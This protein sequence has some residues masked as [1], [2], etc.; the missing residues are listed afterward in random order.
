MS[1]SIDLNY[2]RRHFCINNQKGQKLFERIYNA[3]NKNLQ[4]KIFFTFIYFYRIELLL[5]L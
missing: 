3:V 4:I 2:Y 1:L 5:L